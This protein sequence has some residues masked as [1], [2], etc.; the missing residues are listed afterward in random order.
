MAISKLTKYA[1][2]VNYECMEL[3]D[4]RKQSGITQKEAAELIGVPFR[5][6]CRYE[7]IETYRNT[8]KY[9]LFAKELAEKV[10]IDEEHGLLTI[11]KIKSLVLPILNKNNIN[12]CY[13]F[14]SYARGEAREDSDVDLLVDTEITGMEF[15]GLVE[16]LRVA[17]HK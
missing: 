16:E 8:Y 4:I 3:V 7:N 9:K 10:K 11:E 15:F 14:G 6:Y 2:M 13:L 5:T 12:Y 17:L 1:K